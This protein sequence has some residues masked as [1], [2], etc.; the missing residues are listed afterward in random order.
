[1]ADPMKGTVNIKLRGHGHGRI[2]VN[3]RELHGVR[4]VRFET[5][6]SDRI[7]VVTVEL[8]AR[9]VQIVGEAD[10]IDVREGT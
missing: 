4:A 7:N 1:M 8:L 9:N 5:N 3:G 2:W 6:T 10:V